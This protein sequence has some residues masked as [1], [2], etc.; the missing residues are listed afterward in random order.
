MSIF[1]EIPTFAR[2]RYNKNKLQDCNGMLNGTAI[3]TRLI[4]A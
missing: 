4:S 1:S 2:D 3:F